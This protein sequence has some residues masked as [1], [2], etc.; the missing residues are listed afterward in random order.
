MRCITCNDR[1]FG[2]SCFDCGNFCSP[3]SLSGIPLFGSVSF[4]SVFLHT[5]LHKFVTH[6]FVTHD[7]SHTIFRTQFLNTYAGKRPCTC[8]YFTG[9]D[10]VATVT[11]WVDINRVDLR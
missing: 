2:Y 3:H 6:N 9:E 7:P 5:M 4:R 10:A 1:N 8:F 11:G